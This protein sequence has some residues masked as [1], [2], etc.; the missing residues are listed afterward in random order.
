MKKITSLVNLNTTIP[1][2]CPTELTH[3]AVLGRYV[4]LRKRIGRTSDIRLLYVY[5]YTAVFD[6]PF[7]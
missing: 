6:S 2:S 3:S 5:Y 4:D 1:G 7:N